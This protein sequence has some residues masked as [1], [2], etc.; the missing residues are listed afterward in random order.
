MSRARH[1]GLL[2]AL[3]FAAALAGEVL[4]ASA[5]RADRPPAYPGEQ[6]AVD[7]VIAVKGSGSVDQQGRVVAISIDEPITARQLTVLGDLPYLRELNLNGAKIDDAAL[8]VI[9]SIPHLTHLGLSDA[10]I[11]DHGLLKLAALRQLKSLQLSRTS[12]GNAGLAALRELTKLETLYLDDTKVGDDGL[13]HLANL[14]RLRVL[15]LDKASEVDLGLLEIAELAGLA[16]KANKKPAT[17]V[18]TDRGLEKLGRHV[19]LRSLHLA[20]ARITDAGLKHLAGLKRL[21]SLTLSSTSIDGTGLAALQSLEKLEWLKLKET[22]LNRPG[23][24]ALGSLKNVRNLFLD[25]TPLDDAAL[26]ELVGLASLTSLSLDYTKITN[27]AIPAIARFTSLERLDAMSTGIDESG[28][29][30]LAVLRPDCVVV[31]SRTPQ[32]EEPPELAKLRDRFVA[33]LFSGDQAGFREGLVL[34]PEILRWRFSGGVDGVPQDWNGLCPLAFAARADNRNLIQSLI[35]MGAR[36]SGIDC[37]AL[38][39]ATSL[40][41]AELLLRNGAIVE[42]REKETDSPLFNAPN[43]ELAELYLKHGADVRRAGYGKRTPLHAAV[44]AG[45]FDVVRLLVE[46]GA[47]IDS[48]PY[49]LAGCCFGPATSEV[50]T[51]FRQAVEL[52]RLDIAEWLLRHGAVHDLAPENQ[53]ATLRF[54]IASCDLARLRFLVKQGC[55]PTRRPDD[56]EPL[57]QTALLHHGDDELDMIRFLIDAGVQVDQRSST[58]LSESDRNPFHEASR[59]YRGWTTLHYA[60]YLGHT[61]VMKILLER[62]ADITA[63]TTAGLTPLECLDKL[64]K[65]H[66]SDES[67]REFDALRPQIRKLLVEAAQRR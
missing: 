9:A 64:D 6:E 41:T 45:R 67:K 30:Q 23:A 36:P 66:Y 4:Q 47:E 65:Y 27:G 20:A 56:D 13:D 5:A 35:E 44:D 34:F 60:A 48:H 29:Q 15:S 63:R 51:P 52:N 43:R 53:L 24:A 2:P 32:P 7:V 17:D 62:G 8:G 10:K 57:L 54:G 55:D 42:P 37:D 38:M 50:P 25:D 31:F 18:I 22:R 49:H 21:E 58:K 46:R 16:R 11:T 12:I 3:L 14:R 40:E 28:E 61:E 39:Y 1:H 59:D 26:G 33:K 19:Q